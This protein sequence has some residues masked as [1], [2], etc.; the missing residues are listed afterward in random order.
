M[1]PSD[2]D[3]N[4]PRRGRALFVTA[5]VLAAV[6]VGLQ[7]ASGDPSLSVI[8]SLIALITVYAVIRYGLT[9]KGRIHAH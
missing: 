1:P 5:S 6:A 9:P 7:I 8:A 4:A 3:R 2:T